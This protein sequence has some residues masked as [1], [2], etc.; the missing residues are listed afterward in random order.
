MTRLMTLAREG[1]ADDWRPLTRGLRDGL[2]AH[3]RATSPYWAECIGAD[4]PF[5]AIPPLTKSIVHDRRE[6]LRCAGVPDE[7]CVPTKTSGSSG[8]PG[9][10]LMDAHAFGAHLAG[11]NALQAMSGIPLDATL[12]FM[13]NAERPVTELPADW[14]WFSGADLSDAAV[15]MLMDTWSALGHYWIL[16]R[17]SALATIAATMER[18][19][20]R[21]DPAPRA[22]VGS[23]DTLTAQARRDIGRAFGSPVRAWYGCTEITGYLAGTVGDGDAY[24]VN[25][26]LC[27]IEVVDDQARPL[28]PGRLGRI[29]I[30]DLQNR[31]QPMIRYEVGDLGRLAT[32]GAGAWP[33]LESLE[34]RTSELMHRADG[35]PLT[36]L[37]LGH[38]LFGVS[39]HTRWIR[40]YQFVQQRDG[41]IEMH[42]VW[43]E[44]P[45]DA[46][47]AR[48]LDDLRSAAGPDTPLRLV[49]VEA[50]G[51]LPSG[52]RWLVRHA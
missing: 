29:L 36:L 21:P 15:T 45:G 16:A 7:R 30:T 13:V 9:R 25:P 19:G 10:F 12:S 14:N 47:R 50:L 37:D 41:T 18:L 22:V 6:D 23:M 32:D 20:L 43:R 42:T 11:R 28:P 44:E 49:P 1:R 8:E 51:T 26:F 17:S 40:G 39:D 34:G 3:A 31:V 46:V 24:A 5:E 52:K 48:I 27:H 2:V 4:T 33:V 38:R 35:S